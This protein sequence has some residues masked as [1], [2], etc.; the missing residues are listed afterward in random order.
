MNI[1]DKFKSHI[2]KRTAVFGFVI[3]AAV[4]L[5][6]TALLSGNVPTQTGASMLALIPAAFLS[7]ILSFLSPCSLPILPAY[8]AYSFQS[9]KKNIVLMT[10]AFF[11]G[12]ATTMTILGAS[13]TALGNLLVRN[14]SLISYIGGIVI[15]V[16]GILSI[17]GKGFA[18]VQF[19]ESPAKT[20][21]G[22]FLYGAT[23]AI[24]WTACIGP[25]LGA[26]LTLLVTQGT[27]V[28]QGTFLS[29]I[30]ALGLGLPLIIVSTFFSKLGNGTR[31]WRFMRGRGFEIK[32]GKFS[33]P[34]HSTGIIS[35]ILMMI[36]GILLLTGKL[37]ELTQLATNTSISN[38]VVNMDEKIR[39]LFGLR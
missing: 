11:L 30:Y 25:I 20:V 35:G 36:M 23:F 38:W 18:G 6:I 2:S 28:I 1:I 26:I 31:F 32:L 3:I 34:L 7:G 17:F 37:T 27:G 8:F 10:I 33:V 24:G 39:L 22:S 5:I 12:L 15:I 16:F 14:I 29:F 19:Q 21:L 13:I 4:A 9:S